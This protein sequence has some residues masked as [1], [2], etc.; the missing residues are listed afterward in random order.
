MHSNTLFCGYNEIN[1]VKYEY[2]VNSLVD[3]CSYLGC[4]DYTCP[5]V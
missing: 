4:Q 2:K 3:M 1:I 5:V